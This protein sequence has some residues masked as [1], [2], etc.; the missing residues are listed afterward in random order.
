MHDIFNF[1]FLDTVFEQLC[2]GLARLK[3][4]LLNPV[5]LRALDK[6]K[7]L[8]SLFFWAQGFSS[9]AWRYAS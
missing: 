3:V 5:T 4:T 6:F 8:L 1:N 2:S 7:T 9:P